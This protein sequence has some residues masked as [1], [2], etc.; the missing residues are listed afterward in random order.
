MS[1]TK[2]MSALAVATGLLAGVCWVVTGA[3]PLAAA[4]QEVADSRGVSVELNGAPLMHRA[5]VS[6]PREALENK[7]QGT[8]VVQVKLNGNGEVSDAVVLSGPEELRKA[9][10]QS[11][12]NWHF[13]RDAALGTR[14]VA[15]TFQLP[16][17]DT[18]P[19]KGAEG[20]VG[21]V[22]GGV[23][24]GVL[25]GIIG[26]VPT[27]ARRT[28]PPTMGVLRSIVV[29][30]LS[31]AART[32]LLSRLPVREGDTLSPE[33]TNEAMKIVHDFDSHLS[34]GVR[35]VGNNESQLV[36]AAPGSY[37]SIA[38]MVGSVPLR[39]EAVA[40]PAGSIRVGGN[41]Q[42]AKLISQPRPIYPALAK[43]ARISGTVTMQ[44]LIGKDGHVENMSLVKGHPLLA[45]AALD[46][47]KD[48]VYEPTL[49]NGNPVE[50]LTTV[51]VN[52]T[53]SQ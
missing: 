52:F 7:V 41:E 36:I 38:G 27:E 35:G 2:W 10:I 3:F 49:L 37:P 51:D 50:V 13:M 4:P 25:G 19:R 20:I 18:T 9:A 15:I 39:T 42:Q 48:W 28:V 43:Q 26:S 29:S 30:G 21:G 46:A 14:Q 34:F 45:S 23:R 47:V 31:D 5:P 1:K 33:R 24:A 44:V 16:N 22:P 6:Y 8:V 17:P 32:D 53:L 11:V 40:A 12:L